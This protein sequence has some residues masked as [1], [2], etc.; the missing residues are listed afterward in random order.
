[1]RLGYNETRVSNSSF[2]RGFRNSSLMKAA[3]AFVTVCSAALFAIVS[4]SSSNV[5]QIRTAAAQEDIDCYE[6]GKES[7]QNY[8]KSGNADQQAKALEMARLCEKDGKKFS[9]A[10]I[11]IE[12]EM[13]DDAKRIADA[14]RATGNERDVRSAATLYKKLGMNPDE[15]ALPAAAQ[16]EPPRAAPLLGE[17]GAG[18]VNAGQTKDPEQERVEKLAEQLRLAETAESEKNWTYAAYRYLDAYALS[19]DNGQKTGLDQKVREMANLLIEKGDIGLVGSIY[20]RLHKLTSA[21]DLPPKIDAVRKYHELSE[22]ARHIN[23]HLLGERPERSAIFK[24]GLGGDL[25]V[26]VVSDSMHHLYGARYIRTDTEITASHNSKQTVA[27]IKELQI[28]LG[29]Q[30]KDVNVT[31]KFDVATRDAVLA[32]VKEKQPT[33]LA[34]LKGETVEVASGVAV[35]AQELAAGQGVAPAQEQAPTYENLM[36]DATALEQKDLVSAANKFIEACEAARDDKQKIAAR[37]RV[38]AI[39]DK[40]A[41]NGQFWKAAEFYEDAENKGDETVSKKLILTIKLGALNDAKDA[42]RSLEKDPGNKDKETA[43]MSALYTDGSIQTRFIDLNPD[44]DLASSIEWMQRELLEFDN[45]GIKPTGTFGPKTRRMLAE[46]IDQD[47]EPLLIRDLNAAL[48]QAAPG[49]V[50]LGEPI[51][52]PAREPAL[53]PEQ[54][55]AVKKTPRREAETER[56]AA[57]QDAEAAAQL[58]AQAPPALPPVSEPPSVARYFPFTPTSVVTAADGNPHLMF[59]VGGD[60]RRLRVNLPG[61]T[62]RQ[63]SNIDLGG[64]HGLYL[65]ESGFGIG[66][67]WQ[68]TIARLAFPL[69]EKEYEWSSLRNFFGLVLRYTDR[70]EGGHTL[71]LQ[72][73]PGGSRVQVGT[74][75][76]CDPATGAICQTTFGEFGIKGQIIYSTPDEVFTVLVAGNSN[77][78]DK[79]RGA[80]EGRVPLSFVS[81]QPILVEVTGG[82][83]RLVLQEDE[84]GVT[85]EP[86][87][88]RWHGALELRLPVWGP[89]PNFYG[90]LL[91]RGGVEVIDPTT[92][93]SSRYLSANAGGFLELGPVQLVLQ[94]KWHLREDQRGLFLSLGMLLGGPTG[95]QGDGNARF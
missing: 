23:E 3:H 22:V 81:G 92:Y 8:K 32:F 35:S 33:L 91:G 18:A 51:A 49:E 66:A 11:Y 70:S 72:L 30:G 76:I 21:Q 84:T 55:A 24:G 28:F 34:L 80:L 15:P 47:L 9:A 60:Y 57:A 2:D 79:A 31:G 85:G 7:A 69:N 38:V 12:L 62:A 52:E 68:N 44:D 14:L 90:G 1:M 77:P 10:S 64:A 83:H 46:K 50:D 86:N 16:A 42:L 73:V 65:F 6:I 20:F 78:Y 94:Y 93:D 41:G 59:S 74:N 25:D 17:A 82:T 89:D 4:P 27:A 13:K 54:R 48:G 26:N 40:L 75:E 36:K 87:A 43:V 71:S 37:D 95:A 53:P 5:F 67:E 45:S 88:R 56:R 39:A 58:R 61:I 29:L 19:R 63:N